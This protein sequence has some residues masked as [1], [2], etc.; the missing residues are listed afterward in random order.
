MSYKGLFTPQ[1]PKKY[2]GDPRSIIY[3]SLWEKQV[4]KFLDENPSVIEWQSDVMT[5]NSNGRPNGF[6]IP[7]IAP[8]DNRM[9]RYYPD[10]LARIQNPDGSI[11][12][13]V[14]EVKPSKETVEPRQ[15]KRITQ[16]YMKEVLTWSINQAKW[17]AARN[18]CEEKGWEFK[19]ITEKELGKLNK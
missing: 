2:K 4:M 17:E 19:I 12:T 6:F 10:F 14:I 15:T 8:A 7:Y 1:N 16:K 3:R 13:V 9:H 11:R 18:L 5:M